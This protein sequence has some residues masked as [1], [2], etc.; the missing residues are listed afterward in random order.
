VE[1]A[2]GK[3]NGNPKLGLVTGSDDDCAQNS[4]ADLGLK[5]TATASVAEKNLCCKEETVTVANVENTP[6][7][8]TSDSGYSKFTFVNNNLDLGNGFAFAASGSTAAHVTGNEFF[9]LCFIIERNIFPYDEMAILLDNSIEVGTSRR[10]ARQLDDDSAENVESSLS[11]QIFLDFSADGVLTVR[12]DDQLQP[13]ISVESNDQVVPQKEVSTTS[14]QLEDENNTTEQITTT[15]LGLIIGAV[16]I[17]LVIVVIAFLMLNTRKD[18]AA[19][20]Y[21]F[22]MPGTDVTKTT[23][24]A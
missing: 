14:P 9:K 10:S 5:S 7:S 12:I 8:A 13:V 19:K 15:L 20:V 6:V 2:N 18:A 11:N 22:W 23:V 16:I 4:L 17:L 1:Y 21:P 3:N 24:Q